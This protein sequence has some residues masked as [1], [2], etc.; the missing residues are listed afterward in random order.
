MFHTLTGLECPGCG[1]QR[2]I[3]ALLHG[4]IAGAWR[5]N[6][7][8]LC[9][10][11]WLLLLGLTETG[12]IRNKSFRKALHSIPAVGIICLAIILWTVLRNI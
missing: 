4:D 1:S 3:H 7:F 9:L 11:P 6:A 8:L 10:T 5:H 2:M 12:I